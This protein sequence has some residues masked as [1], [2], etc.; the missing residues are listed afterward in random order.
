MRARYFAI[1]AAC[2]LLSGCAVGANYK[3]PELPLP[4]SFRAPAPLPEPQ[5]ASLADLKWFEVFRDEALQELIRVALEENYDLRDAMTRV[6]QARANLGITRS[7][8]GPQLDASN[9]VNFTRFSQ[10]GAIPLPPG[11]SMHQNRDYVQAAT[12][13][14]SFEIDLWGRLRL[15]TEAARANLLNAEE[16]RKVVVSTL[17]G[18]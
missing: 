9:S 5:A 6:E 15:A 18:E 1:V 12:S 7:N 11:L 3:R 2:T 17:V 14:L 13:R 4:A 16:N 8:Q 10:G